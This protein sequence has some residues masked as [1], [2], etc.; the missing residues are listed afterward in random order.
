MRRDAVMANPHGFAS[1]KVL[2]QGTWE[3]YETGPD[4]RFDQTGKTLAWSFDMAP[5]SFVLFEF[6]K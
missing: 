5:K 6:G 1:A 2:A 3:G 4:V